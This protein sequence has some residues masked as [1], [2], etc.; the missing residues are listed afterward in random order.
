MRH[1][2]GVVFLAIT[3]APIISQAKPRLP[4]AATDSRSRFDLTVAHSVTQYRQSAVAAQKEYAA[5]LAEAKRAYDARIQQARE[6]HTTTMETL[7][8]GELR[9][10]HRDTARVLEFVLQEFKVPPLT[11]A[12]QLWTASFSAEQQADYDHAIEQVKRVVQESG[13]YSNS[14]A[15]LRF[16]W[17][18]YLK[19]D[20]E[21]A[22]AAY[23]RAARITPQAATPLAGLIN[24]HRA[25]EDT[26]QAIQSAKM[27]LR[28]VPNDYF[29]NK[30]LG[31]L[32]YQRGDYRSSASC[33]LR[34]ATIYPDDLEIANRLAWSYYAMG[35]S[36]KAKTV[37]SN[38][39]AIFPD[40]VSANAG[41]VACEK[42]KRR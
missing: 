31:E 37:F 22:V 1:T 32:Y 18:S 36:Q 41:Y 12:Q 35:Q 19:K 4:Q 5:K 17:L 42:M 16:A 38:V 24:C 9:A 15:W 20:Y 11:D 40:H 3:L 39:L 8:K 23:Q 21:T 30:S 25:R 2:I 7:A 29:A 33:Y 27:L 34:L 6:S 14:Y 26:N 28:I 13:D 10:G